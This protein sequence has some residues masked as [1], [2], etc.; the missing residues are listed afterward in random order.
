MSYKIVRTDQE[1]NM[2]PEVEPDRSIAS[3]LTPE[4][5]T[6]ATEALE[7]AKERLR[8]GSDP[9]ETLLELRRSLDELA[10]KRQ[11]TPSR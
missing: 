11:E 6:A 9:I 7:R 10:R 5:R 1:G 4:E 3:D 2:G 8:S